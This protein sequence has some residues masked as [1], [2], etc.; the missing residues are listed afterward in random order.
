MKAV[1]AKNKKKKIVDEI[2]T[3]IGRSVLAAYIL[4]EILI[5]TL[6]GVTVYSSGKSELMLESESAANSIAGYFEKYEKEV[7][8][9]ALNSEIIQ[10]LSN[11]KA[12]DDIL[13]TEGMDGVRDYL[14]SIAASDKENL[15]A[16]WIADMDA[17]VISQSD[18]FTSQPGWDITGRAWYAGV[19]SGRTVLT[20][21]YVDSSTGEMIISAVAPVLDEA[22]NIIGAAG[23]DILLG[24]V[25]DVLGGYSIGSNGYVILVSETGTII[26]HPDKDVVQKKLSDVNISSNLIN[27]VENKTVTFLKY[28]ADGTTKYGS[29]QT[30]GE[31]GYLVI[32]NLPGLE[33]FKI[34][35]MAVVLFLLIFA[36]GIVVVMRQIRGTAKKLAAPIAKLND[37]ARRLADG[38][39]DVELDVKEENEIGELADAIGA[40]VA[41]LKEYIA[42]LA[43]ASNALDRIASGKLRIELRQ[44]YAG[45][46][47]QL[48]DALIN[49]S[50]SINGVMHSISSS[51]GLVSS[52]ANDLSNAAQ[53]LAEG[54]STHA[55]AVE[56]LVANTTTVTEQ[57]EHS[58]EE[59]LRS[60]EATENVTGLMNDSRSKMDEMLVAVRN[61]HETSEQV[62]GIIKT[63]EEIADQTNLL[64][65]NASIEA[66]RAGDAGKGFAVVADEIGK[67]AQESAKAASTTRELISVSMGEIAKGD[68]IAKEVMSAL[69]GAVEAVDGVNNMIRQTAD[70]A[71]SQAESMEQI[72]IGIEEIA[73]AVQDSSAIAQESSATSQELASQA[74]L[75]DEMV[76]KFELV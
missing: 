76:Q 23:F 9:V 69:E 45:E 15:L 16:A 52:S 74:E 36:V 13:K 24:H 6:M 56:E 41:R 66:A 3:Q 44:E 65:L 26:Y 54:C 47:R 18:G 11:T 32:S 71:V 50:S 70:S 22:G 5:V 20:E 68:S 67:L 14:V 59:A 30:V 42:Y 31:T 40:T 21:P 34:F 49:I 73:R 17:S 4:V 55:A 64:S 61:I 48:K 29:V 33:F 25:M 27:A 37:T 53:S 58:K 60:A 35:I 39:L 75:L 46:F 10:V 12:G 43:E 28:K 7:K 57:V 8:A 62:V 19:A 38:E 51:S 72:K 2:R 63:I 1:A